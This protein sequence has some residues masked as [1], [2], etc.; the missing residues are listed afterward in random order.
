MG[1]AIQLSNC[2]LFVIQEDSQQRPFV[3]NIISRLANYEGGVV[4]YFEA[5][6]ADGGD[7]VGPK[8]K[9]PPKVNLFKWL[10]IQFII[11]DVF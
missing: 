7:E 6:D 10:L 5:D 4:P 3:S 11:K 1:H 9:L 8:Q 2:T